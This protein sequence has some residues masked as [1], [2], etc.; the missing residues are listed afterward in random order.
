MPAESTSKH[1]GLTVSPRE[2][3]DDSSAARIFPI[4]E[5]QRVGSS[6]RLEA[7]LTSWEFLLVERRRSDCG[8]T[9]LC[10]GWVRGVLH[11]LCSHG[12]TDT[13]QYPWNIISP[14]L[15]TIQS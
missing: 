4:V 15:N 1:A 3:Q 10:R 5:Y 14:I 8:L 2:K 12:F 7:R 9:C 6:T 13:P 11:T